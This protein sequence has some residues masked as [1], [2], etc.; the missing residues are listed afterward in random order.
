MAPEL[1]SEGCGAPSLWKPLEEEPL[2][3]GKGWDSPLSPEASPGDP[4][5]PCEGKRGYGGAVATT[6]PM[7]S[8]HSGSREQPLRN[9]S[10]STSNTQ[11]PAPRVAAEG[12]SCP[13]GQ[14][15]AHGS[16]RAPTTGSTNSRLIG[17]NQ[18]P[19]IWGGVPRTG[20]GVGMWVSGRGCGDV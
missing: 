19:E 11:A 14:D 10:R 15:R 1:R 13:S 2:E 17:R 4:R 20:M 3:A 9:T 6:K 5:L 8:C 7:A 18:H 16:G 12:P